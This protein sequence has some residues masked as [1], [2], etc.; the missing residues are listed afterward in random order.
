MYSEDYQVK[1]VFMKILIWKYILC[2]YYLA[3]LLYIL[4]G[5][6]YLFNPPVLCTQHNLD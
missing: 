5:I 3:E 4:G 1:R 6:L 2:I